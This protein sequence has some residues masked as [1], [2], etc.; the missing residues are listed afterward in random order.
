M[1]KIALL[2]LLLINLSLS[3]SLPRNQASPAIFSVTQ[4]AGTILF[5][6]TD[7]TQTIIPCQSV[8][9]IVSNAD[10]SKVVSVWVVQQGDYDKIMQFD[11]SVCGFSTKQEAVDS[12]TVWASCVYV[13][14]SAYTTILYT[15]TDSATITSYDV[16]NSQNAPPG[17]PATGDVYLV[18]NNPS[19]AWV[20]HAKDIAEWNGSSWDFT[21]GV[22][23]DFLY[24]ATNALTYIFRS[25]NW[26][27]TT[28]IPALNNGNTISSGLRIG[29]N[30]SR[31]LTF[32]TNNVNRGRFDSVG[33]FYVYDTSLRKANKYLQIDSITGRLIAS[34]VSGSGGG[35]GASLSGLTAATATNSIANANYKQR[36]N[37]NTISGDTALVIASNSVNAA[38]NLQNLLTVSQSGANGTS[39]QTTYGAIFSNK[40][41]GTSSTN[42]AG[43]FIASGANNNYA[44]EAENQV[45]ILNASTGP[46]YLSFWSG[47][48]ENAR[49]GNLNKFDPLTNDNLDIENLSSGMSIV[50]RN[51]GS[52]KARIRSSGALCL[53]TTGNDYAALVI[54]G[55]SFNNAISVTDGK[56]ILLN[57]GTFKT[58]IN[59]N[60]GADG[61]DNMFFQVAGS[62]KMIIANAN[63][64][65]IGANTT[66]ASS[67][68]LDVVSTTKGFLP[69]RMTTTQ[70][71]A[72]SSPATGLSVYNTTLNSNDSYDGTRWTSGAKFLTATATLDFGNTAAGTV[73]DLT[74]TVTGAADGDAVMLGVPNASIVAAGSYSAWV[75]A[76]NTVTV[77]YANNAL[78]TAYD[79]ASGTFKLTVNK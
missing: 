51:N 15:N 62:S 31:S 66:P 49:I 28:G 50:F 32:E 10:P 5:R 19:G 25:G 46:R 20:G 45:K 3:F 72:I 35:G 41:T 43:R 27:Q 33:R 69:P 21:D 26:V 4:S 55:G 7:S 29:T 42:I 63:G 11:Y 54:A 2:T 67:A 39:T 65:S 78:V 16:L 40:K 13:S 30:N 14:D 52:E 48:T 44:I 38:S 8:A 68:I 79:P 58:N 18:G 1:K 71:D 70:R 22:Q 64:V 77:R 74:I 59:T 61:S 37:W 36:W 17:S 57:G 76:T 23:G 75:S 47:T 53:G 6:H 34:E 9:S 73:S 24:N 12:V 56:S 60:F